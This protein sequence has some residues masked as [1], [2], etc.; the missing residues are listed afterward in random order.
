MAIV[1]PK[2]IPLLYTPFAMEIVHMSERLLQTE[3]LF[4]QLKVIEFLDK[5]ITTYQPNISSPITD[6]LI[7]ILI[8]IIARTLPEIL[9]DPSAAEIFIN[10]TKDGVTL[11]VK[12][13]KIIA[14]ISFF[15]R[16]WI[17]LTLHLYS[18]AFQSELLAPCMAPL[19]MLLKSIFESEVDITLSCSFVATLLNIVQKNMKSSPD[20]AK[21]SLIASTL[22]FSLIGSMSL[23]Q[24]ISSVFME[25]A[26]IPQL[27]LPVFQCIRSIVSR[28]AEPN[29]FLNNFIYTVLPQLLI[30]VLTDDKLLTQECINTLGAIGCMQEYTEIVLSGLVGILVKYPTFLQLK[31]VIALHLLNIGKQHV[32]LFRDF[33]QK[34][35]PPCKQSFESCLRTQT[36]SQST[37]PFLAPLPIT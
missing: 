33:V 8:A 17:P 9:V 7:R 22:V 19:T 16:N 26:Y 24:S 36:P 4:I 29:E 37:S 14:H 35:S 30:F 13:L 11:A 27:S 1:T 23:T 32:N 2:F 28:R 25:C 5:I 18:I 31:P 34:L 3:P 10:K 12:S 21:P 15:H 20:L 6:E